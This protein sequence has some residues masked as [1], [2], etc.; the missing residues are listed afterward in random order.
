MKRHWK[1]G[2]LAKLTGL[3]VRTLRFYD[4]IGLFSPSGQTESGH[5]LYSESDL[6]RLHQILSLKELGLS[7]EEIKS[8]LTG[9]QIS[10][11]EIVNLQIGRIKEQIRL[12][13]KL[14]EQLGHVSKLMQ[15]KAELTL[16]DFTSLLQAM[17]MRFEKPVIERQASWE[18]HLDALGDFLT[19][20]SGIPKPKEEKQ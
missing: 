13:Q 6:S 17:K 11:L 7:L 8:A 5:R 9:G 2:D 1:V 12:Q 15:G 18:R 19:E 4:Q 20:E 16:E 14:L 10:P 3:T